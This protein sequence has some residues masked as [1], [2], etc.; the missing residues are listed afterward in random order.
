MFS[1]A[2]TNSAFILVSIVTFGLQIFLVQLGGDFMRTSP[3]TINQWLVT[4]GLGALGLP[5]GVLMRFIPVIEDPEVFFTADS[6]LLEDLVPEKSLH[7]AETVDI[8]LN[9]RPITQQSS[10]F[11]EV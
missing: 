5:V 11:S 1:G 10:N 3:L 2:F 7:D 9:V 4:I 8:E 6:I